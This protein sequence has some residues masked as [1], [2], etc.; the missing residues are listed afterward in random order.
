M[1]MFYKLKMLLR[2]CWLKLRFGKTLSI[3][4]VQYVGDRNFFSVRNG[5]R[6]QLGQISTGNNVVI[7]SPGGCMCIGRGVS[8]N[9]NCYIVCHGELIVGDCCAFGPSVCVVDHNH[10]FD[11]MGIGKGLKVG[12]IVIGKKCW[13]GAN[14]VI[15]KDTVIGDG[16]V[17][18]AGAVV[19]G[20]IPA[21]SLVVSNR[22]LVVTPIRKRS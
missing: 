2:T 13:I 17:I 16:C 5:G 20:N 22:E 14:V 8:F 1:R 7:S 9:D 12:K 3:G 21:H 10:N 18:G 15:L 19:K 6:L 4:G 11:E